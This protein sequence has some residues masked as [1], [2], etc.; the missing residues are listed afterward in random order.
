MPISR[1]TKKGLLF[2]LILAGKVHWLKNMVGRFI[3]TF[4]Y[5]NANK[6]T[7]N[8]RI[9]KHQIKIPNYKKVREYS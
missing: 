9:E 5:N 8:K 3:L 2:R 4:K 7:S 6:T 1:R